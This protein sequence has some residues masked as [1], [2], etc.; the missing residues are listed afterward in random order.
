M[1]EELE[2]LGIKLAK[3]AK[4]YDTNYMTITY[5]DKTIQGCNDPR[6]QNHISI[7]INEKEVE[8]RCLKENK[9]I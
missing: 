3:L 7:F 1:Q 2:N 6:Q 5:I 8:E 9:Q 4:E